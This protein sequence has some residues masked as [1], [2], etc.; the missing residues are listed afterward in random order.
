[1]AQGMACL[2]QQQEGQPLIAAGRLHHHQSRPV[3]RQKA[4]ARR[5]RPR[6][7]RNCCA[8]PPG[9]MQASSQA[10]E[11]ST[12]QMIF[13]HGNLPCR[14][15]VNP[16]TVRSYVTT[17]KI[18]GSPTV[19]AGGVRATSPRAWAGGHRPEAPVASIAHFAH[20]Q[21]QGVLSADT[22]PS[23]VSLPLRV[24]SRCKASASFFKVRRPSAAYATFS[25][26]GRREEGAPLF[27]KTSPPPTH[28]GCRESA[29]RRRG[30]LARCAGR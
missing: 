18:P 21:I 12:P 4:P 29:S 16:A 1:M 3:L 25:H 2:P 17:A 23:S 24:H 10:F 5:C 11:T 15:I 14:A 27:A 30:L 22:D 8:V 20:V 6:R 13:D 19:V 28:R 26:K 7:C 9:S